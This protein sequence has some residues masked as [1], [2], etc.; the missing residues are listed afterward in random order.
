MLVK[1]ISDNAFLELIKY[2]IDNNNYISFFVQYNRCHPCSEYIVKVI[3]KEENMDK[4]TFFNTYVL[5]DIQKLS[6]Q[7]KHVDKIQKLIQPY[8]N[9]FQGKNIP[10]E[11][12]V[13]VYITV[14]LTDTFYK[15]YSQKELDNYMNELIY[16]KK[17]FY[18]KNNDLLGITY[19]FKIDEHIKSSVLLNKKNLWDFV[20]PYSLEDISFLKDNQYW[21][22]SV[23]H[24]KICVI[25]CESE[26]EYEYLKSIG[27]EF[28]EDRYIPVTEE[29]RKR[30]TVDELTL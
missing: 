9:V 6:I 22:K 8:F 18:G 23:A 4:E 26:E 3:F 1:K 30:I 7:Y 24:E 16:E 12:F 21:L 15:Y 25:Y 29:E 10:F 19:Y 28:Y 17:H 27:V 13:E 14:A 20:Y 2:S 5:K 11:N